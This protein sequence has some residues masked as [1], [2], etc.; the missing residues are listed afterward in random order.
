[1][2]ELHDYDRQKKQPIIGEAVG[3]VVGFMALLAVVV[4]L[5]LRHRRNTG[6]NKVLE[7]SRVSNLGFDMVSNGSGQVSSHAEILSS[8]NPEPF[9]AP[10]GY[11]GGHLRRVVTLSPPPH[12]ADLSDSALRWSGPS[13]GGSGIAYSTSLSSAGPQ[14]SNVFQHEDS[15]EIPPVGDLVPRPTTASLPPR[16]DTLP[17]DGAQN[18]GGAVRKG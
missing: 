10:T 2:L 17:V 8:Y 9:A 18:A 15:G 12:G 1:M 7:T 6:A 4:F 16:Y 11:R 13:A 5:F 3:G 14:T